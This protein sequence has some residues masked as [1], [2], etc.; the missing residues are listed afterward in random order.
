M[1]KKELLKYKEYFVSSPLI[2]EIFKDEDEIPIEIIHLMI[3]K[4]EPKAYV[5]RVTP[6]IHNYVT[7]LIKE[8]Y[9]HN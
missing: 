9:E 8:K 2:L 3:Y 7:N 6:E 1:N 4:E 5:W